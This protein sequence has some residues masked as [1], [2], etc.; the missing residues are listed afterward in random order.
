MAKPE[1]DTIHIPRSVHESALDALESA[2]VAMRKT[3]EELARSLPE[4]SAIR[5]R[6]EE[7]G[8]GQDLLAEVDQYRHL[9]VRT[10]KVL[11]SAKGTVNEAQRTFRAADPELT[12]INPHARRDSEQA[13]A[14]VNAHAE[15]AGR[16]L[17]GE[18]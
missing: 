15:A 6:L 12:P 18:K 7:R 11:V 3:G 2:T 13:F 1:E 5:R 14:A 16:A 9:V 17:R 4:L 8:C 10:Q